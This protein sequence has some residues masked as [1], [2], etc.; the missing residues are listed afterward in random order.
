MRSRSNH[1]TSEDD[2]RSEVAPPARRG[3][4]GRRGVRA[5]G[6]NTVVQR[7][8]GLLTSLFLSRRAVKLSFGSGRCR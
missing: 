2:V 8:F 4:S 7:S 5:E 6:M 1:R 3:R